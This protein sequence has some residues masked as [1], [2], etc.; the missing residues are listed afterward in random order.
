MH[1]LNVYFAYRELFS[2]C[3]GC[4]WEYMHECKNEKTDKTKNKLQVNDSVSY[5]A[6]VFVRH[7]LLLMHAKI[8]IQLTQQ[9]M[10]TKEY[11]DSRRRSAV[12]L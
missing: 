10:P 8:E 7:L 6:C 2:T 5:S 9:S 3:E 11:R 1:V 12:G 4:N